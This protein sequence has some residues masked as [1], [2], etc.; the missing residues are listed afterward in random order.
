MSVPASRLASPQPAALPSNTGSAGLLTRP[1][2]ASVP[3]A[4]SPASPL[5]KALE[6]G[7]PL[8]ANDT[9]SFGCHPGLSC[10]THCCADVNIFLTPVDVLRLSRQTGLTTR[11]FLDRHTIM[12]ITKDLHLPVVL[13]KMDA[14]A[15]KRCPFVGPQGCT[16]YDAR[17][18]ACRMYPVATAL[19]PARAGV[20]VVPQHVLFEDGFCLG[21]T[22]PQ[23][24]TVAD[25]QK[26][27]HIP[28]TESLEAGFRELVSHP[29]F[30]GGR[31]LDEKRIELFFMAAYD[32]DTF[33]E[34]VFQ[35]SF[36]ERFEVDEATQ[37][38]IRTDDEGLLRFGYQ[39]LKYA[40]FGEPTMTVRPRAVAQG[41][42]R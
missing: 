5:P 3:P 12:P 29:W 13:L 6:R 30:I 20:E 38:S 14:T 26:D 2:A 22:E 23:S 7:R 33:R 18:W 8:Q 9:F 37:A 4:T 11:E 21:H 31:Q 24:W 27:Q 41:R 42:S 25:W 17:P 15:E 40:L 32:L 28:E 34:F 1:L 16:V 10:F 19:P 35:S 39:W 36:L